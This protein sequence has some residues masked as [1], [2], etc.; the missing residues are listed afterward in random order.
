MASAS[1]DAELLQ[2]GA[3]FERIITEGDALWTRYLATQDG[4]G[5]SSALEMK[6]EAFWPHSEA[7][8]SSIMAVQPAT[9]AGL[10]LWARVMLWRFDPTLRGIV[11]KPSE[12]LSEYGVNE[13]YA[14]AA[15]IER[16]AFAS[17][18]L[19]S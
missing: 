1:P 18:G 13:A 6:C 4:S 8:A 17:D 2:L 11:A 9:L 7:L 12:S 5:E 19:A 10:A 15:A 16:L 3:E 14:L